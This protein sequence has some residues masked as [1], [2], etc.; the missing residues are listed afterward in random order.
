MENVL[1]KNMNSEIEVLDDVVCENNSQVVKNGYNGVIFV[2]VEDIMPNRGQP[3][4]DFEVDSLAELSESI[5]ENGVIQPIV[6]R[7]CEDVV[8]S[9]FDYELVAGERRLRAAKMAGLKEIPCVLV[10]IDEEK[11]AELAIIENL[12]RKEYISFL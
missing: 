10:D 2:S 1:E 12:H 3:R 6:V 4:K 11:S 7:K 9:V 5:K 8:G